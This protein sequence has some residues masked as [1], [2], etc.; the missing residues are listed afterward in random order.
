MI[1][2]LPANCLV[3]AP[4]VVKFTSR[5]LKVPVLLKLYLLILVSLK[6]LVA[7]RSYQP[8]N[9][10]S[11]TGFLSTSFNKRYV[12]LKWFVIHFITSQRTFTCCVRVCCLSLIAS[13]TPIFRKSKCHCTF[14]ISV[15]IL[16]I[17]RWNVPNKS[18]LRSRRSTTTLATV[19][20]LRDLK[21]WSSVRVFV[22]PDRRAQKAAIIGLGNS[23]EGSG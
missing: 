8:Y 22:G 2:V 23:K 5:N 4:Y 9:L 19:T 6:L 21:R 17:G 10:I 15:V 13:A 18:L 12:F 16:F 3:Q 14:V 7:I 1:P 11:T 20:T